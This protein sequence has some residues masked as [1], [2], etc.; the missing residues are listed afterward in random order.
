MAKKAP[1]MRQKGK[2]KAFPSQGPPSIAGLSDGEM[3]YFNKMH[4]D[5]G[6][7]IGASDSDLQKQNA[8]LIS[9]RDALKEKLGKAEKKVKELQDELDRTTDDLN[10]ARTNLDTNRRINEGL[11]EEIESK[12]D[13]IASQ[14]SRIDDLN[15]R[16]KALNADR[17]DVYRQQSDNRIKSLESEIEN[18]KGEKTQLTGDL[19]QARDEKRKLEDAV[20]SLERELDD[21]NGRNGTLEDELESLRT[22]NESD[23]TRVVI[24]RSD[25]RTLRSQSFEDGNYDIRLA[26]DRTYITFR[27]DPEGR[28]HCWDHAIVIPKLG[29]YL[30]FDGEKRYEGEESNGIIRI[31]L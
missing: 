14:K 25:D 28:A 23:R 29:A 22:Q 9:E 16:L 11:K 18:L 24:T 10:T 15:E 5:A 3:E 13:T 19:A 1:S 31:S 4:G 30:D 6:P 2:P 12:K 17:P 26:A 27:P 21:A 7:R 20:G 8:E